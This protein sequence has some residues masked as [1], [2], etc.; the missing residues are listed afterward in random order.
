MGSLR[1]ERRLPLTSPEQRGVELAGPQPSQNNS[2]R[3]PSRGP[4]DWRFAGDADISGE[5]GERQRGVVVK[6]SLV[7][8]HPHPGPSRRGV[9]SRG[10]RRRE[11]NDR[12]GVRRK[13]ER[14]QRDRSVGREGGR[15]TLIT[16][17]NV[18]RVS[19]RENNRRRLRRIAE[20][21]IKEKWEV[22][23]LTELK[24]EEDGVVWLGEEEEE[25]ALVHGKKAGIMLRG[26]A[27]R[28]WVEEG[29]QKWIGE[30]VVAVVMGGLRLV[31]VYQPSWGADVEGMERCRRDMES[32]VA[33]GGSERLVIGGD[34]NASVGKNG[35]IR[36]VCGSLGSGRMNEAGRDLIE[37]CQQHDLAYVNSFCRYARRGTWRHMVSGRWYELDGF[38]VKGSERHRMVKR[39]CTKDAYELSDHRPVCMWVREKGK[40]WRREEGVERKTPKIRWERLNEEEKMR[41]YE[42]KTREKYLA[43]DGEDEGEDREKEWKEVAK[44]MTETAEEVC[45]VMRRE[46]ANPW[47]VGREEEIQGYI[48]RIRQKVRRR[49]EQLN[50]MNAMRRLRVRR[51][52]R[53]GL[54]HL[55][56]ERERL[57]TEV[58]EER[59]EM[60]RFMRRL[61]REWWEGVIEECKEAMERGRVGEMYKCLRKLGTRDGPAGRSTTVTVNEF[62]EHF[63]RVSADRYEEEPRVIEEAV[64][65]A[66]D[67]RND[68]RAIEA[69]ER[70]NEM[71]EREEIVEVMNEMRESAPG[72]DGV[73]IGYI[74]KACQEIKDRV[75]E[76]VQEMFEVRADRWDERAK[77]GVMV[78]LH[79]KGDRNDRNNYRGVCLLSMSSRVLGRVIAKRMSRWAEHLEL[80]DENQAGFRK[81][82]ST[83]D[84]VQMMVRMQEDVEDDKRRENVGRNVRNEEEWPCARMLDLRKAYP[85]VS[86]PALW[87][88]LERYGMKGRCM[89]TVMDLH[90]TTEYKVRGREGMS[91][92][93]KPARGLREGCST[94][95]ILFN[96]YH[97]AVMRQ[98]LAARSAND[99]EEREI[100]W[101]WIP[102]SSFAGEQG[103]ERGCTEAKEMK[104]SSALFADDT[105]ILGVKGE[106]D[107]SVRRVKEVMNK[108]EE[109]N[110][111]DKEEVLEFGTQEGEEVRVL[112][113]WMGT[114]ADLSNRKRRAG[115]LWSR[116]KRWLKGSRLSKR[117]Q[118]RVVEACV[119]CSLLYDC[120]ARVWYKRDVKKLQK[121]MDKCYRYVWSDRN[122]QPL[123][124]MQERGVNMV[125]VRNMLGVKSIEW[126]IER[127]VLE[128]IGH[129]M[130]M[131]NDR[132]TKA[133]VL[134]WWEGLEGSAKMKGR[135]K[136]TVLYWKRVMRDAG[137]DWTQVEQMTSNRE[138]WKKSVKERMDHLYKWESQKGHLYVWSM[139]ED[140]LDRNERRRQEGFTCRYEECGKVCRSRAG[141]VMHEKRMH[142]VH[143]ERVRFECGRCDR[144]FNAE[145]NRVNHER[146]CTGGAQE[147][148]R[149]RRQCGWCDRWI[150]TGNYARHVR[151]CEIGRQRQ[152]EGREAGGEVRRGRGRGARVV[153]GRGGGRGGRRVECDRC[154][155]ELLV[156]NIARH[157]RNACRVWDPGGG[158]SP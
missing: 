30:R 52:G 23:L 108:W 97:Q 18:R 110:N 100:V 116:V 68:R 48:E 42:E 5:E 2:R 81:G 45:G 57:K 4:L 62:K 26:T 147:D 19:V 130:R 74:R 46:L 95:P 56:A 91:E 44:V 145:G 136:K 49:D 29:Q 67:L 99:R 27:L 117:W 75:I 16:T 61:E 8:I 55:E 119:E 6:D 131:G 134:G 22:V 31:S 15:E 90:E 140:R 92:G 25:V 36:G 64:N 144:M 126:K 73:R 78:P 101:K 1:E 20:R 128:R 137:M 121:W 98:A 54:D 28:R 83:A 51:G 94:S 103:W 58:K 43:I 70:L 105:T 125:D 118:G 106:M 38:L 127:R 88:L 66:E 152:G 37:W 86:K 114:E 123:R 63:E 129:V 89:E 107:E 124:Q 82:R 133:M 142:R 102:G 157:Q 65:G 87:M 139:D 112:G 69:N 21:V 7:G 14:V 155:R 146:T 109:R 12:R 47:T 80:L 143:E 9:R 72:E 148:E 41:E 60:K 35:N 32:Q 111:D 141:L 135:K 156:G 96:I 158:A 77:V 40:R 71:P 120:Q 93:W 39:M 104:V 24:A 113:S 11:R 85:R 50:V 132:V 13:A 149:G 84:V 17:W 138:G 151:T 10:E 79:K 34:F 59:K 153:G 53:R 33:M 154:G 150:M 122:G 76:I 3:G 115:M